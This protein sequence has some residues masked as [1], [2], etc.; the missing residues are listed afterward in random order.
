M[1]ERPNWHAVA[2]VLRKPWQASGDTAPTY[3]AAIKGAVYWKRFGASD[4]KEDRFP[5]QLGPVEVSS[6]KPE[7]RMDVTGVLQDPAY[8]KTLGERLRLLSATGFLLGKEEIYDARYFDG[9]Y[10]WA[11]S[12]GPRAIL[13]KQPK[14]AVTLKSGKAE[15]VAL[16]P[17]A[18]VPALA[19]QQQPASVPSAVVPT[20][21]ELAKLN[22]KFMA[23]PEWMPD[24]QYDHVKQLMTLEREGK[25]QPFY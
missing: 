17:A 11:V 2:Y 18:D 7:G 22:E 16:A 5:T 1:E 6:Y 12:T 8:G 21:Q 25:M 9:C 23:K 10:E 4:E 14:L 24:W 19:K 15:K 13:I 20:P 3:N